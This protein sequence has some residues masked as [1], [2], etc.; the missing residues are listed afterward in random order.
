M[1]Y[2]QVF[3]RYE[4]KYMLTRRQK[5][6]ILEAMRPYMQ[7]DEYGRTTIRNIYYDTDSFQ[8]VRASI[9]KPAYKEKLRI[10]SY[11]RAG[12]QD[13][14]FVELKKKYDSVVYKRRLT[15]PQE[16]IMNCLAEDR[17]IPEDSQ[18]SREIDYFN[19]FYRTLHPAA[20][21]SYER[22]AFYALNGSDLRITFDEAIFGRT[23]ELTL[24]SQ[25]YGTPLLEE[26][27]TLMEIK[28]SGGY[29]MWLVHFLTEHRIFKTSFSKYGRA[30]EK[31][32]YP[33]LHHLKPVTQQVAAQQVYGQI[34]YSGGA[35]YA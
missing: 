2:Q 13:K 23:E 27:M 11:G 1:K 26:G 33:E 16:E 29:P 5:E 3:K 30:Y 15:M 22:E 34:Q 31:I 8:L 7:L 20:F 14:V 28:T 12:A 32:I 18:I 35:I 6:A 10:R 21:I 9:M 24:D 25:A 17:P 19:R 4:L